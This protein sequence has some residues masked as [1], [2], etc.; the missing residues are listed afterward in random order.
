MNNFIQDYL[1]KL[2]I[3]HITWTDII[4]IIIIAFVLYNVMVWIKKTKAWVLLRGIIVVALFAIFAYILN[5]KTILWI[6]GKT[7][8]VG[9]IALVI[10]F[11]PELRRA[12]EQLGRKKIVFGLFRF[13]DGRDKGERFSSKTA[14]EIVRACYDM[15]AAYTG[16]LIVVEQDMILEEYEKTGIA[17]DGIVTSQLLVN[18]FEHNTPL[19]DGAVIIRGDRVV[20]ATCYLPLSDNGNLNKSLGTRHRAGVGISEVTDS[21]TIIVSE[22]TGKVSVAVGGELIHD[23]DADS[24]RNKLEYLRRR[25]IDVKSFRIWRGRLKHEGKDV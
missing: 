1:V 19:H 13:S 4:E 14:E 18:I 3:P 25:T 11:Q 22:E 17:V 15:G 8:S 6:A 7:I 10:I 20:A 23:I 24:L 5:L 12:L 16:A 2:Y 21:M 9:I